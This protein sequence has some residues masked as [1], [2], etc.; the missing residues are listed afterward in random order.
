MNRSVYNTD[1][2]K[3]R[4]ILSLMTK[5]MAAIW[6]DNFLCSSENE[7]EVYNFPTYWNFILLLENNFQSTNEKA[8]V[9]V[10]STRADSSCLADIV[11]S[12]S[13]ILFLFVFLFQ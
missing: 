12:S 8:E 9:L 3:V 1:E 7:L 5:G 11:L 13:I 4:Y 6:R 10:G 2:K